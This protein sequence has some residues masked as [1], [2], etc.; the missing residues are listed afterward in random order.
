[1]KKSISLSLLIVILIF[2][3]C[4]SAQEQDIEEKTNSVSTDTVVNEE[5]IE[6][7][8]AIIDQKNNELEKLYRKGDMAKASSYFTEDVIQLTPNNTPI[9]GTNMYI[10]EWNKAI[11]QG[12]WIFDFRVEELKYY[13]EAAVELG[14]Y[15]LE[16]R[17]AEGSKMPAYKDKGHYVVLWEKDDGEWKI[18]WDAPVSSQPLPGM[19]EGEVEM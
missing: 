2:S 4:Q 16:I 3:R 17:P 9:K 7:V 12:E 14:S 6:E 15:D 18:V 5:S 1:M 8:R 10:E 19:S 13:G 11:A